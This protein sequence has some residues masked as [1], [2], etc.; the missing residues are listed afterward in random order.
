RT[1][2]QEFFTSSAG[3]WD[4]LREELFGGTFHLLALTALLDPA[5]TVGDLGCGTGQMAAALAPAVRQV[6]AVDDS[7]AMLSA[8]RRRVRGLENVDVRRGTLEALPIDDDTLDAATCVLVLH[9]VPAPEAAFAE[10]AR[11]VRPGGRV[12]V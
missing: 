1:K 11:V 7:A 6:I 8:A 2:S 10:M 9:H 4:R 12:L 3:Q 5:W